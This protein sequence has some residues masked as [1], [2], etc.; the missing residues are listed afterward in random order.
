M[1]IETSV[2]NEVKAVEAEVKSEVAKV[3]G[4][5]KAAVETVGAEVKAAVTK[6][7]VDITS[8]EKLFLREAELEYLKAQ[9]EIQKFSKNAEAKSKQYVE[10]IEGLF[11]KYAITKVEYVFDGTINAFKKL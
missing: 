5:V 1:S 10:Y 3:E 2:E 7:V 8:E 4:E 9:M 6:A 11:K